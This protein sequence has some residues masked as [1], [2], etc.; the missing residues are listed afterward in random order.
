MAR[1]LYDVL[2]VSK[3]ASADDIK[4]TYRKLAAELHPDKN[5]GKKD[6]EA[7]FKEVNHAHQVLSDKD[8]RALYDEFGEEGLREG[9]DAEKARMFRRYQQQGG[10]R[11]GGNP[12]GGTHPFGGGFDGEGVHFSGDMGDLFGDLFARQ[13]RGSRPRRGQDL[14]SAITIDFA[15]AIR[16]VTLQI[17]PRGQPI[18]VR[19]PPGADEGSR[20]RVPG[21]GMPG[22]GGGPAGDLVLEI[23]VTPHARF[24]R[25]GDDLHLDLPVTPG[26]AFSGGKIRVPTIDGS[27]QMKLPAG[28]QSGQSVRLKGKGVARKGKPTGDLYV[29]VMVQLPAD[30]K[31]KEAIDALEAL[32]PNDVRAGIEL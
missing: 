24:R 22:S 2:G 12:F 29:R 20:V 18:T 13:G 11:A 32:M 21:E 9:F 5:P 6:A 31:A 7:K 1:D 4:K 8:K 14:E 15:S 30:P 17:A 3:S 27:V 26:E 16:G 10:G 28:S 19:I 23:H 25:E